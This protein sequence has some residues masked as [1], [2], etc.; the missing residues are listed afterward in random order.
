MVAI[1][2]A[3]IGI[4]AVIGAVALIEFAAAPEGRKGRVATQAAAVGLAGLVLQ[5]VGWMLA[6]FARAA[7]SSR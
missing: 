6:L 3:A 7:R 5:A 2:L 1:V 4:L